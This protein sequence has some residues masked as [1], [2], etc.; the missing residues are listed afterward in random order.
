MKKG[1]QKKEKRIARSNDGLKYY[2]IMWHR[3]AILI[4]MLLT[5][6][7]FV[8]A[9]ALTLRIFF[10]VFTNI[11]FLSLGDSEGLSYLSDFMGGFI[12]ILIGL[13][14][15]SWFMSKFNR[16]RNYKAHIE[17]LNPELDQVRMVVLQDWKY[18]KVRERYD[19]LVKGIV[20]SLNE[21]CVLFD[22]YDSENN[23]K[24]LAI[25]RQLKKYFMEGAVFISEINERYK[26]NV[27]EMQNIE[28]LLQFFYNF[29][30]KGEI[31]ENDFRNLQIALDY[32]LNIDTTK[33]YTNILNEVVSSHDSISLF[34]N[35][36]RWYPWEKR[37]N[38]ARKVQSIF[39]EINTFS[40]SLNK[41]AWEDLAACE[42]LLNDIGQFLKVTNKFYYRFDIV[43]YLE[44]YVLSQEFYEVMKKNSAINKYK[45]VG[46]SLVIKKLHNLPFIHKKYSDRYRVKINRD[47]AEERSIPS[48]FILKFYKDKS[49]VG[50]QTG[51]SLVDK[52]F[53]NMA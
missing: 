25:Y 17:V 36:P 15:D 18:D 35:L 23:G 47:I 41:Y 31:G 22:K 11:G 32:Y 53:S 16:L 1:L 42:K 27:S 3:V 7:I 6:L 29:S 48:H 4:Y 24:Y 52:I 34:Y 14:I 37:G 40:D 10:C 21:F 26:D 30:E 38:I 19:E 28:R 49:F 9:F 5:I 39:Y 45:Y 8:F 51:R 43:T 44:E 13:I 20:G 46:K 50:G 12:G 2:N 33:L